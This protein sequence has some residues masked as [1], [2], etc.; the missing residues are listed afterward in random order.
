MMSNEEGGRTAASETKIVKLQGSRRVNPEPSRQ[1][2][3][4]DRSAEAIT[5]TGRSLRGTARVSD[6]SASGCREPARES[7]AFP[8]SF[9]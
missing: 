4:S 8:E 2:G 7:S 9:S 5:I 6:S 1:P 3:R